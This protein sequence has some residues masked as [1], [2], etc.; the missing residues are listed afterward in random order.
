M[1]HCRSCRWWDQRYLQNADLGVCAKLGVIKWPEEEV[2]ICESRDDGP[3]T[4]DV[5]VVRTA[6]DFGCVLHTRVGTLVPT[7]QLEDRP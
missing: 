4:S 5:R 7:E 1:R 3:P 2:A 6:A